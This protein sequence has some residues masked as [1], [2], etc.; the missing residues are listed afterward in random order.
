MITSLKDRNQLLEQ[1]EEMIRQDDD[2]NQIVAELQKAGFD[3]IEANWILELA[4]RVGES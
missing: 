2:R 3:E 4:Y 1:V